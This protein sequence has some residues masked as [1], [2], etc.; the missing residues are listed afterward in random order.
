MSNSDYTISVYELPK[1]KLIAAPRR[2]Y[3]NRDQAGNRPVSYRHSN[4]RKRG[5]LPFCLT[6]RPE[7]TG[8]ANNASPPMLQTLECS[9]KFSSALL[10]SREKS[11]E[12]S[13]APTGNGCLYVRPESSTTRRDG[14]MK[15]FPCTSNSPTPPYRACRSFGYTHGSAPEGQNVRQQRRGKLSAAIQRTVPHTNTTR[16]LAEPDK[17]EDSP[18]NDRSSMSTHFSTVSSCD[19]ETK[20]PYYSHSSRSCDD[21]NSNSLH[22]SGSTALQ[23]RTDSESYRSTTQRQNSNVSLSLSNGDSKRHIPVA[24]L[25]QNGRIKSAQFSVITTE[26]EVSSP[27][28]FPSDSDDSETISRSVSPETFQPSDDSAVVLKEQAN[29]FVPRAEYLHAANSDDEA[30]SIKIE[31]RIVADRP[32]TICT[33]PVPKRAFVCKPLLTGIAESTTRSVNFSQTLSPAAQR[34]QPSQIESAGGRRRSKAGISKVPY[35]GADLW[36]LTAQ[37]LQSAIIDK[38]SSGPQNGRT[39]TAAVAAVPRSSCGGSTAS[40][41]NT[42]QHDDDINRLSTTKCRSGKT[43][44][45][46][47]EL[48]IKCSRSTSRLLRRSAEQDDD[49]DEEAV[50]DCDTEL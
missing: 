30:S 3:F 45:P 14:N 49:D 40:L 46:K 25:T 50:F 27:F 43:V 48:S 2:V 1:F 6:Q 5:D 24:L 37:R 29:D 31:R 7:N 39:N 36:E 10:T 18:T 11:P 13:A 41:Q 33:L 20:Q 44:R 9:R 34:N 32:M 35:V 19:A 8:L 28:G 4:A 47:S 23:Q 21:N 15:R 42:E 12:R 38:V 17:V 22:H 26:R 16:S